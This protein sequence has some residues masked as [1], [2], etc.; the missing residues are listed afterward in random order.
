MKMKEIPTHS[1]EIKSQKKER[2]VSLKLI[3]TDD[4]L[5]T[6]KWKRNKWR[7]N[8]EAAESIGMKIDRPDRSKRKTRELIEWEQLL[9]RRKDISFHLVD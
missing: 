3:L 1:E 9:R 7:K 6:L 8:E 4:H 5:K 2:E